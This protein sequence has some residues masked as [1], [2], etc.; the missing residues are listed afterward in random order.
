[1]H[2]PPGFALFLTLAFIVF[3]FRR[4]FRE[5]PNVTGALWLPL[6]WMLVVCSRPVSEWLNIFGLP[7]G[8]ASSLEEGSPLDACF[9]FALIGAGIYVLNKRQVSLSEIIRNNG[10]LMAF[11]LYCFIAII[12]SHYP[13]VAFKR[14][15][16]I[17][18]LPI[19][20]LILLTEPDPEEALARLM[21]RC[22]YVIIP[23]SILFIKYY[24][25]W[26]R[27]FDEWTGQAMNTGITRGK[28]ALGADGLI[29]GLFFFWHLL[30]TWR[31]ERSRARRNEL[32][33]IGGFLFM[34]WWLLRMAQSATSLVC[35]LVG[36]LVM[37]LLGLR[38]VNRRAI[39]I[40]VLVGVFAMA[41]AELAFGISA[42]VIELLHRNPTLTDRTMLWA[43]L[44]KMKTNPVFGVGFESFWLGQRLEQAHEG[45]SWQPNEAHNGYLESYLSLGLVGLFM[46]VAL[47]IATFRKI[48]LGLLTNFQFGRFRLGFFT[49]VVLYN[50]TEVSFRGPHP[51]WLVF[52]IV[53]MDYPQ[54]QFATVEESAEASGSGADGEL[55]LADGES[56][57]QNEAP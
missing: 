34:I 43:N 50:W 18:G 45:F 12:W 9:Y 15:I 20:A 23:V 28:N 39:G 54:V 44:L 38:F 47:L 19:M 57:L 51:I 40:Y 25:E 16:K 21:K 49:A 3:L 29:L 7:V 22:A 1:M 48:R 52:Y 27:G 4:D 37:L 13:F 10:W 32:L 17:L 30:Q 5:Q 42:Y 36:I 6:L 8:G 56:L 31:T 24:P 55:V 46:L 26:G 11:L 41:A 2:L 33:V 14:W 35:L 53:A